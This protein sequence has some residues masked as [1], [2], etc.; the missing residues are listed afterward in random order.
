MAKI[1]FRATGQVPADVQ[2]RYREENRRLRL[3]RMGSL[4]P[5]APS[6]AVVG[7][8]PSVVDHLPALRAWDG[9]IWAINGTWRW[10]RDRGVAST[11]YTIDPVYAVDG[12]AFVPNVRVLLSDTCHPNVV[13]M[14]VD[15]GAHVEMAWLGADDGECLPGCTAA[16][17]APT[18]AAARGHKHVT[19]FGC[20][21]SFADDA[22]TH[23]FKDERGFKPPSMRVRVGGETFLTRP[24]FIL[25]TEWLAAIARA[26]PSFLSAAPG[27]FLPALIE[28]GDYDVTHISPDIAMALKKAA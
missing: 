18:L 1:P 28:A 23:V 13:K 27:G 24:D 16:A 17:T 2:A 11:L 12:E 15:C 25:Q 9:E 6:L 22:E 7:G 8:G 19:L 26:V 10:F 3:P 4:G 5:A 21:G 20:E 14:F